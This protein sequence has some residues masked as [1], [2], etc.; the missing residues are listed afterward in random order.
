MKQSK[1]MSWVETILNTSIG[2]VIAMATQ[3]LVFPMFGYAPPLSTNFKIACIFTLVSIVRGF[4][5]R[6]F[7]EF[8]RVRRHLSP[9]MHAVIAECFRQ[10]EQE[11]WTPDH[12]DK[13][14]RGE[15]AAA[16][17]AYL[18]HAGTSSKTVPHEWPWTGDWWKPKDY[19]RNLVRGV[20]LAIKEGEKFDR[21]RKETK[22]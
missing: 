4:V 20:A 3:V 12:D 17:A 13:H 15:L 5:L 11:G 8:I 7:F 10:V 22:R 2:F 1:L 6:R 21:N 9:F 16:G 14:A 18:L 19:R